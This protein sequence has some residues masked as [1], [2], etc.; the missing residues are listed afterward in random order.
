MKVSSTKDLNFEEDFIKELYLASPCSKW[1][2][3]IMSTSKVPF[4]QDWKREC[5]LDIGEKRD[6]AVGCRGERRAEY[7]LDSALLQK[8]STHSACSSSNNSSSRPLQR[9]FLCSRKKEVWCKTEGDVTADGDWVSRLVT[10]G[11]MGG[12]ASLGTC[13]FGPTLAGELF[14]L[15]N[16][17]LRHKNINKH[18]QDFRSFYPSL[19]CFLLLQKKNVF[20]SSSQIFLFLRSSIPPNGR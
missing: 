14:F 3:R 16:I 13:C 10:A 7:Y 9:Y 2:I 15:L 6:G 17:L 18:E 1:P 19:F 5:N 11:P 8:Q 4:Q 20:S 12:G